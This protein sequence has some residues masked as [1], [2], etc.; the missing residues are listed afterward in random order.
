MV[1]QV[2]TQTG[3]IAQWVVFAI[4]IV[5]AVT[6]AITSFFRPEGLKSPYYVNVAICT[7]AATAYYFMATNYDEI[8]A[9]DLVSGRQV[10]YARYIDWILTTPLLLLDLVL[11]TKMTGVM[12]SWI[13]TADVFMIVFGILGAFEPEHKYKWVYF[14]AGCVMQVILTYGMLTTIWKED[15]KKSEAYHKSYI[16]LLTF[17]AVLWV[18]YP[19]VWAFG[20]GAHILSVD[21][22]VILMAILDVLAKPIFAMGCLIAHET[23]L[24]KG[25]GITEKLVAE[26]TASA[27]A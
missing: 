22:E 16:G 19:I 8:P 2:Q 3:E 23:I 18:F 14:V 5:A 7:I 12:I 13:M 25:T 27:T 4:M 17:L 1:G 10:V 6:Y 24:K 15:L 21:W 11:M 20:S 9:G 26:A